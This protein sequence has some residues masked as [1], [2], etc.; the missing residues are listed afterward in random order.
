MYKLVK[1]LQSLPKL[2][3]TLR[4]LAMNGA[5]LLLH[6]VFSIKQLLGTMS[7]S[8]DPKTM[9]SSEDNTLSQRIL[10]ENARGK[11][12]TREGTYSNLTKRSNYFG[13]ICRYS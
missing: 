8:P 13:D 6:F 3:A 9:L 2:V 12:D 10:T 4:T 11:G 1:N 7:S 5:M